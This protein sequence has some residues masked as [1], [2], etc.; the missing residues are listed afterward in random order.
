VRRCL[1]E[2]PPSVDAGCATLLIPPNHG[3]RAYF[4]LNRLVEGDESRLSYV[5]VK[6]AQHLDALVPVFPTEYIPLHHYF[7]QALDLMFGHLSDDAGLPP[8]Q[9]VRPQPR[10]AADQDLSL[11]R[12]PPIEQVPDEGDRIGFTGDAVVIPE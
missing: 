8:S 2:A 10:E 12:L 4:R 11:D 9:V 1:A 6:D 3:S 7:L 5:E